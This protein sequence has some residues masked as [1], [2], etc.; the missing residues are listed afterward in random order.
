[1]VA[2]RTASIAPR[3]VAFNL[4]IAFLLWHSGAQSNELMGRVV[5][6]LDGDT[7]E[8]LRDDK[9]LF[10]VRFAGIDAPEKTQPFG[11]VAK[12][13]MS[14]L[15]YKK[16]VVVTWRKKDRYGRIVGKVEHGGADLGLAMIREG[17]SWH[18][19]KYQSEQSKS[20][21]KKYSDAALEA[22]ADRIGLWSDTEPI[23]P[24]DYRAGKR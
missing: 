5:G 6:V 4:V 17:L 19:K 18:F 12:K 15:A 14:E 22:R 7:I 1:M 3:L 9:A 13:M 8:V 16:D 21:R 10:R 23:A 2:A 11:Q 24:W 20:D